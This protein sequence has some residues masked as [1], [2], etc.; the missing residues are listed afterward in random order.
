MDKEIF[1]IDQELKRKEDYFKQ[2]KERE[3]RLKEK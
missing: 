1:N 3:Q 2:D